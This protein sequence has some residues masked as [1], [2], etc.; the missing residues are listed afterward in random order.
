[1]VHVV[2]DEGTALLN[3]PYHHE[4]HVL[5]QPVR[6]RDTKCREPS[7]P[8]LGPHGRLAVGVGGEV[9][10]VE[11]I[12]VLKSIALFRCA[13]TMPKDNRKINVLGQ[14]LVLNLAPKHAG[15]K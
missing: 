11:A 3:E 9:V 7:R 1:M 6:H 12:A 2:V 13:G 10:A 4:R 14:K 5:H 8:G 15:R